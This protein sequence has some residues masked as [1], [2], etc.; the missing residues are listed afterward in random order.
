LHS[1]IHQYLTTGQ[2]VSAVEMFG[3]IRRPDG[4]KKYIRAF[5]SLEIP[6]EPDRM[7]SARTTAFILDPEDVA[8]SVQNVDYTVI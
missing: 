2:T 4:T 5:D 7:L 3:A 8:I 6:S 1:A